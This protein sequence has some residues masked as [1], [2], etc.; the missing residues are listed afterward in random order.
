MGILKQ[1]RYRKRGPPHIVLGSP[2]ESPPRFR[3]FFWHP[4]KVMVRGENG[5][6]F[7]RAPKLQQENPRVGD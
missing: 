6:A 1:L 5:S 3:P 4:A 2:K 7:E